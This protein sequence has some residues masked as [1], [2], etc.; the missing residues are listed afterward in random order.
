VDTP[1]S[2]VI[3]DSVTFP[4]REQNRRPDRGLEPTREPLLDPWHLYDEQK[5]DASP[6]PCS[7]KHEIAWLLASSHAG[8][9]FRS[10]WR[11]YTGRCTSSGRLHESS[12]GVA[13]TTSHSRRQM[14]AEEEETSRPKCRSFILL[15][16]QW[17]GETR[18][19]LE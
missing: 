17:Q 15:R 10:K 8:V 1:A 5:D 11:S 18:T 6:D 19:K 9:G 3:A 12:I 14:R 2:K 16:G 7:P 4:N 13:M